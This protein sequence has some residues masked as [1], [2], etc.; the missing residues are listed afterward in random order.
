MNISRL[1]NNYVKT[2]QDKRSIDAQIVEKTKDLQAQ[3]KETEKQLKDF[4]KNILEILQKSN[5]RRLESKTN[6]VVWDP[7]EVSSYTRNNVLVNKEK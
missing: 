1:V 3:K 5:S 4:K 6:F 7:T 2:Y